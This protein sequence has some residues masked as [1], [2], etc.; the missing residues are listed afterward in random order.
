MIDIAV[1]NMVTGREGLFT[2]MSNRPFP[3]SKVLELYRSRNSVEV[4]FRDLK[5]GIDWRPA[6]CSK[7]SAIKG[8]I[9]VSFPALFCMFMVRFPYPEFRHLSAESMT[10]QLTVFSITL[11]RHQDGSDDRIFSNFCPIIRR[12]RGLK[13]SIPL[14]KL[15]IRHR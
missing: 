7:P 15:P 13:S 6:D 8:R 12:F 9:L 2:L 3:P 11:R 1:R 5:H 10:K 14:K 4:A